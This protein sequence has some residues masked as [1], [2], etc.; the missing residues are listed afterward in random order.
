MQTI[1]EVKKHCRVAV[2]AAAAV[3]RRGRARVIDLKYY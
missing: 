2:A 1:E 3:R